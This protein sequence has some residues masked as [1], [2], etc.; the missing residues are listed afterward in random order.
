MIKTQAI[1]FSF[2]SILAFILGKKLLLVTQ[3]LGF[4]HFGHSSLTSSVTLVTAVKIEDIFVK[5]PINF[6][7]TMFV[8]KSC[9][10]V[11]VFITFTDEIFVV[12]G[13]PISKNP[14]PY[15]D[16]FYSSGHLRR[17]DHRSSTPLHLA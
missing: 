17:R 4:R 13:C 10:S 11:K 12:K 15:P 7:L 9:S 16:P 5:S 1:N 8:G 3:L 14:E 6:F 2:T